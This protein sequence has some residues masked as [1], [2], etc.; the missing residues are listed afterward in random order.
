MK[1]QQRSH[2]QRSRVLT[3]IVCLLALLTS[4]ASAF[5]SVVRPQTTHTKT[6][7][8]FTSTATTTTSLFAEESPNGDSN[9][10]QTSPRRRRVVSWIRR[11]VLAGV[12]S[13][14]VTSGGL[15][16]ASAATDDAQAPQPV[17]GKTV[18][19]QFQNL[20]GNPEQSG[21]VVIELYPEW[22]PKGVSRFEELTSTGF[23]DECRLFRVL[24]GF[25]VQFGINGNPTVQE[26]WRSASIGD[27]PVKVSNA[28]GTVVFAT[29]GPNTRT[30]QLFINTNEKGNNFL[31]KQGLVGS[32]RAWMWLMR[33]MRGTEKAHRRARV[34][35]RD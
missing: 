5:S 32:L 10:Q 28:R 18:E 20:Q 27:D 29:A 24:P 1:H 4:N 14:A 16:G 35:T 30:S 7:L 6:S 2:Q 12:A 9:Q 25:I 21:R 23:W 13:T 33:P 3:P 15:T 34:R 17:P 26:K 22:A 11:V 19:L 31:D 8:T